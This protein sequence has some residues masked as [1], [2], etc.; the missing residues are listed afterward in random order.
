M[1]QNQSGSVLAISLVLLTAITLVSMQGL[2]RSALH[3]KI[4]NNIQHQEKL[5][6]SA[7]SDQEARYDKYNTDPE[8][9]KLLFDIINNF[10]VGDQGAKEQ[11]PIDLV[12]LDGHSEGDDQPGIIKPS[13]SSTSLYILGSTDS[14]KITLAVGHDV[15]SHTNHY[16]QIDSSAAFQQRPSNTSSQRTG[17]HFPALIIGQ[18][19]L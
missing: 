7:A 5:F 4:V 1:K 2:Q 11:K 18:N 14:N 8:A 10:D 19:S 9:S 16:F 15:G 12:L 3:T 17:F 13:I 6:R